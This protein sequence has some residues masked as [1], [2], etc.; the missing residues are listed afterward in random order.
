M[1]YQCKNC[2]LISPSFIRGSIKGRKRER[3]KEG[4]AILATGPGRP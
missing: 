4:K 2:T 3:K 1:A